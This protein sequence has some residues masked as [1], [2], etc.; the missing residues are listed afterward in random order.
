MSTF[1][2]CSV[3]TM[4]PEVKIKGIIEI[5][6]INSKPR[7]TVRKSLGFSVSDPGMLLQNLAIL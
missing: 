4:T 2:R 6:T 3:P 7:E 5:I 1:Y